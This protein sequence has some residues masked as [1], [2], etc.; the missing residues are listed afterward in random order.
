MPI[1]EPRNDVMS[2]SAVTRAGL[3]W[4][5]S[6]ALA[7]QA[8][9]IVHEP[10]DYPVGPLAAQDGG[11][12]WT[13]GWTGSGNDVAAP[14]LTYRD[15]T[16]E[17]IVTGNAVS[18]LTGLSGNFR[19]LPSVLGGEQQQRIYISFVGR[20]TNT[21][22]NYA[23]LALYHQ[24]VEQY[25][26]GQLAGFTP[27][28]GS[29]K[30]DGSGSI[31][32][33]NH[34]VAPAFIVARLDFFATGGQ[35]SVRLFINPPLQAEPVALWLRGATSF[36]FD[37]IRV[38]SGASNGTKIFD[39][40]R[41]GTTWDDVVPRRLV[42]AE[43]SVTDAATCEDAVGGA[44]LAFDINL[45]RPATEP[46][47]VTY[48][49]HAG[50]AQDGTDY[51]GRAG[52]LVFPPGVVAQRVH[53]PVIADGMFEGDETLTLRL[54]APVQAVIADATGS[55]TIL[56]GQV[57]LS[58]DD[59]T[60]TEV[61]D[62]TVVANF[63]LSLSGPLPV[64]LDI[65]Y[66]TV[67]GTAKSEQED[68]E[69][70]IDYAFRGGRIR[71][72]AGAVN[73]NI[74]V[75]V[76]DDTLHE[77]PEKFFVLITS[78]VQAALVDF[79]PQGAL[80]TILD[81]DAEI[82]FE[83][84]V[85][86]TSGTT[87]NLRDVWGRSPDDIWAVGNNATLLNYDGNN[88]NHWESFTAPIG[89]DLRI[90]HG[91]G[92]AIYAVGGPPTGVNSIIEKHII[93]GWGVM[94]EQ[95]KAWG[96]DAQNPPGYTV[97]GIWVGENWRFFAAG[98]LSGPGF[99][100]SEANYI[101]PGE[102]LWTMMWFN[103]SS[104]PIR[105]LSSVHG[106]SEND[107]YCAQFGESGAIYHYDGNTDPL[108]VD[109]H[110]ANGRFRPTG[111][112]GGQGFLW[113]G[114][115]SDASSSNYLLAVADSFEG[116]GLVVYHAANGA[117]RPH[118]LPPGILPTV[119]YATEAWGNSIS[120]LFVAGYDANGMGQIL[121]HNGV[122]WRRVSLPPGTRRLNAIWGF[123]TS[124][125][126]VIAVGDGGTI[127]A[128]RRN[129]LQVYPAEQ[130]IPEGGTATFAV[131]LVPA[132]Q[133]TVTVEYSAEYEDFL[134]PP[135][136]GLPAGFE[137]TAGTLVF[138]PGETEKTIT[139]KSLNNN[140]NQY[141]P[142][143]RLYI[144]DPTNANVAD[145]WGGRVTVQEDDPEPFL[146]IEEFAEGS[147]NRHPLLGYM[148]GL[149]RVNVFLT[150]PSGGPVYV[151][152]STVPSLTRPA[153]PRDY[154]VVGFV[155]GDMAWT[156]DSQQWFEPNIPYGETNGTFYIALHDDAE[157]EG[158]EGFIL[159]INEA[160]GAIVPSHTFAVCTIL[161]NDAD[162]DNDFMSDGWEIDYFFT[163]ARNGSADFDGD[164]ATDLHEFSA[165]TSPNDANSLVELQVTV[166]SPGNLTLR[167][168]WV[169]GHTY[170]LESS[171]SLA[172][173]W[174]TVG[175]D[176]IAW[177]QPTGQEE[178]LIGDPPQQFYRIRD[179]GCEWCPY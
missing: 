82:K 94:P 178:V 29:R 6:G 125:P 69:D 119:H 89:G 47:L 176:R 163:L 4:L 158:D 51:N 122:N 164:G 156:L 37:Q 93:F 172:G 49:T 92:A 153:Q 68:E 11:T 44:N 59:V 57:Q 64:P 23:G 2:I 20:V 24:G 137:A 25:F 46:V 135:P 10:F 160:D 177:D 32:T 136:A 110:Q 108:V 53:I 98:T 31:I 157:I 174:Q 111:V 28:W 116:P 107:V 84:F 175:Q 101:R 102:D 76:F 141:A 159:E 54:S 66:I 88:S 15:G 33:T 146:V 138:A 115:I 171:V 145:L 142:S 143:F 42:P 9:L 83:P 127:V 73:G 123:D 74:M 86:G 34:A 151:D 61:I 8:A 91:D 27:W 48:A 133:E 155:S 3:M 170:R 55:G 129:L 148:A 139:V 169:P 134:G 21:F 71:L 144:F 165:Q 105:G 75:P 22:N 128:L 121:H 77:G 63:R 19:Y 90:I 52:I 140:L 104:A 154:A 118:I 45:N 87:N 50:T 114:G 117:L 17:L 78:V 58:I 149:L 167:W 62:T 12:G 38:Q 152:F 35:M 5:L 179:M 81:N 95:P 26:I 65:D 173:P 106:F 96:I 131:T 80:G 120:N 39:E 43:L 72:P 97:R 150:E 109:D 30:P 130:T 85:S 70:P 132:S 1:A 56:D 67:D 7:T 36:S 60:V 166:G 99:N 40:I 112:L 168:S 162:T 126:S 103:Q 14:G 100:L 161:D 16:N 124:P 13:N 113:L 41:I 18:L 79:D 147:E